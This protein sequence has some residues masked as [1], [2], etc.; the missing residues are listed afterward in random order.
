MFIIKI[1]YFLCALL[2][3]ITL[4]C[5]NKDVDLKLN[6]L[7]D[8]FNEAVRIRTD[9]DLAL[10][11]AGEITDRDIRGKDGL[12]FLRLK[13]LVLTMAGEYAEAYEVI[14]KYLD[15]FDNNYELLI[16]QSIIARVL[17]METKPYLYKAYEQL[18]N[19]TMYSRNYSSENEIFLTHHLALVL[20]FSENRSFFEE[21]QHNPITE[22]DKEIIKEL[23]DFY[24][25]A[26]VNELILFID[27]GFIASEPWFRDPVTSDRNSLEWWV[28]IED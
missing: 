1:K 13:L 14:S 19:K 10:S 2:F 12:K 3:L 24:K 5:A 23:L 15:F 4:S 22:E 17:G 9:R 11:V 26:S 21:L 8:A 27:I 25:N 18:K 16:G 28:E 7:N 6:R 20:G